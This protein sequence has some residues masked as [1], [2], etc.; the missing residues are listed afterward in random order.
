MSTLKKI[1]E[2]YNLAK[3]HKGYLCGLFIT[4]LLAN[5]IPILQA[6]PNANVITSLTNLDYTG[7]IV[8]LLVSLACMF[9]Y[10]LC[11]HIN[12]KFYYLNSKYTTTKLSTTLYN[13]ISNAT[14]TG[15]SQNSVEKTMVVFTSN[16]DSIVKFTDYISYESC[17]LVRAIITTII[18]AC[19][20]WII[21]LIMLA[22]ILL[23]YFWYVYLGNLVKKHTD[24][25]FVHR[26]HLGEKL[27]DLVD[28][29]NPTEKLNLNTKNKEQYL[30]QVNKI[31]KSYKKRGT[32]NVVRKYWTYAILY[33]VVTALTIWLAILTDANN[34]TLTIYLIIAPYLISIIDYATA[35]Y[36][37]LYELE[38]TNVA[39]MRIQTLLNM[40]DA[41]IVNFSN[42]KTDNLTNNLVLSNI[43]YADT[44]EDANKSGSLHNVN[45]E[46][47]PNT[48]TLIKGATNCGKRSLF[49][50]LRRIIT[51][52]TGT[53]TMD[54][55]NIYD[56]DKNTYKHNLSYATS[57]PYF[58]NE[59]ILENLQYINASKKKIEKVC[60]MLDIHK[61]IINLP[62]G[63]D[64]NL[65]KERELVSPYLLFMIGLARAI[66][67]QSEWICIYEF[68]LSLTA[69]QQ[70]ILKE[71]LTK[72]KNN[73][74]I[75]IFSAGDSMQDICDNYYSISSGHIRKL[76]KVE[77]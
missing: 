64:T 58:Y 40:P 31:I 65:V 30:S 6:I 69:K 54:G 13:K 72:L 48:I 17:Y 75:I 50:L 53:I 21:G 43:Y 55:I 37:M 24:N 25:V 22:L 63:Y 27:T 18:V 44:Q 9:A 26:D 38:R 47:K 71:H 51:P 32:V 4:S 41:D 52:T 23:L 34:L 20:N 74:A 59:S 15:L 70:K 14:N 62:N 7:A 77:G 28:G 42:N 36:E 16:L 29:R 3:P 57:K 39:R 5:S 1:K 8:W 61:D 35:G 67:S 60:K 49:Y 73:H 2:W 56:F 12:Y 68:P 76:N 11:W 45:L 46:L 66:L 33:V 10:Y 19:Y